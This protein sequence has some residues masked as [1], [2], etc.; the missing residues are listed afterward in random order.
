[1]ILIVLDALSGVFFLTEVLVNLVIKPIM[2]VVRWCKARRRAGRYSW[3]P[4]R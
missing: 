2:A 1:M 4:V 3:P